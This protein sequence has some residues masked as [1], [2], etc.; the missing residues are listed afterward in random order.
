MGQSESFRVAAVQ[1]AP[2]FLDLE[3]TLD[4]ACALIEEAAKGG[5]TYAATIA[6]LVTGDLVRMTRTERETTNPHE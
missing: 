1:A 5:G 4:K 3:A 6:A 2:V